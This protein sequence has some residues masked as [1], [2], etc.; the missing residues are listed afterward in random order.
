M[1]RSRIEW[2]T[3]RLLDG[4]A[5]D[6]EQEEF[7]AWAREEKNDT[8]LTEI[9]EQAWR[10]F[11]TDKVLPVAKNLELLQSVLDASKLLQEEEPAIVRP[12]STNWKRWIGV[13]AVLLV[14]LTGGY[15][16]LLKKEAKKNDI[17]KTDEP[18]KDVKAPASN[19]AMITLADGRTVYLD[20]ANNG[21]LAMQ[22]N[23]K[24]V[25]LDNGQIAYERTNG[26]VI[27][28]MK[29]NTMSNPRGSK[30]IDM[31]LAD[32]SHVW[33]NAGSSVTYPIAFIGNE[34][35][36]T[37]TG[38]AYFE[39]ASDKTKPFKVAKG[40]MTVEVL[41]THFNINAYDD[42]DDIRVTLLEGSVK[43]GL[44]EKEGVII[45][46]G[47]QAVVTQDKISLN[48]S[49]DAEAVMAWQKGYFIYHKTGIEQ[50][51]REIARW[52]DVEVAFMDKPSRLFVAEI[53]RNVNASEFFSILEATGWVHFD[54][55]GKKITVRK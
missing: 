18:E 14:L 21:E 26:E 16:F 7:Y 5:D 25:K 51:M 3:R 24:L 27:T 39:V 36:V 42:E 11:Q 19:R 29:Y 54:I 37:I 44:L 55:E 32:G 22:G 35:K 53:P 28:E 9:M 23:I 48:S 13:A 49:V 2:L 6:R 47:Q 30:V 40:G 12:L 33:L 8:I 1:E 52:Y 45:K 46:P 34:R 43:V 31:A 50:I 17:V 20:S 38:E 15:F 10:N 41:G 4:L